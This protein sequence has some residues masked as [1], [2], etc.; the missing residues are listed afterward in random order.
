MVSQ[1]THHISGSFGPATKNKKKKKGAF[2]NAP[3]PKRHTLTLSCLLVS[4]AAVTFTQLISFTT[5]SFAVSVLCLLVVPFSRY[6]LT[7]GIFAGTRVSFVEY[8]RGSSWISVCSGTTIHGDRSCG[9][10]IKYA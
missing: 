9:T 2:R 4:S 7:A 1:G 5:Y 3:H 6:V 10:F 8:G